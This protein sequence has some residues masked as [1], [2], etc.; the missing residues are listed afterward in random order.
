MTTVEIGLTVAVFGL[1]A[2]N[3]Q[4]S[5]WLRA[6]QR[7]LGANDRRMDAHQRH[8]AA[9]DEAL[10]L[11]SVTPI[12]AARLNRFEDAIAKHDAKFREGS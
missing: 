5:A 9:H 7:H 1:I 12:S 8:L 11:R 2:W 4:T 3:V 6:H 10:R